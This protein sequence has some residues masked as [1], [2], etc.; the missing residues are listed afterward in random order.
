MFHCGA[1]LQQQSAQMHLLQNCNCV[2]CGD[3]SPLK[4]DS[5][6]T[7]ML[8]CCILFVDIHAVHCTAF[9]NCSKHLFA[10]FAYMQHDCPCNANHDTPAQLYSCN[11]LSVAPPQGTCMRFAQLLPCHC[12]CSLIPLMPVQQQQQQ[13]QQCLVA[14]QL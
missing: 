13:P 2:I 3:E 8:I 14:V 7:C 5:V 10:L 1:L 9:W 12:T 6:H 11:M 4:G